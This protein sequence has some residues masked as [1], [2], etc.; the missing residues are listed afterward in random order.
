MV[1]PLAV[2]GTVDMSEELVLLSTASFQEEFMEVES[3]MDHGEENYSVGQRGSDTIKWFQEN[4]EAHL[5]CYTESPLME[6]RT[7]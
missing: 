7:R 6:R 3:A 2:M 5:C 4:K 1:E